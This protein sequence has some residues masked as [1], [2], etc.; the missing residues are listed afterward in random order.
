MWYQSRLLVRVTTL[1]I[2]DRMEY[3]P[4]HCALMLN[5]QLPKTIDPQK[6]ARQGAR[7][8]GSLPLR[9]FKR[10]VGSL[11]SDQ[12]EVQI[13]LRF[14]LNEDSRI[15]IEGRA[16]ALL[17]MICQRCLN[18]ADLPVQ[19]EI[20]LMGVL[21]D[22]QAKQLSGEYDPL[23]LH[24]DP[25]EL[26]S[27]LEDELLLSLP[28]VPFHSPEECT[29][30]AVYTTDDSGND[31]DKPDGTDNPFSVLASLKAGVSTISGE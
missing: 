26:V 19:A 29:A 25:V 22:D 8:E 4:Y 30:G 16:K 3:S 17:P 18:I 11:A 14:F 6:L 7:F 12:G 28:I 21:T 27:L 20:H 9:S 23:L 1:K 31:S 15:V 5:G 2:F 24:D 13:F 10:L